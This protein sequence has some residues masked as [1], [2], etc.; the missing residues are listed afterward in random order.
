M[1]GN[2]CGAIIVLE[3]A[4]AIPQLFDDSPRGYASFAAAS[5]GAPF[6]TG[7]LIFALARWISRSAEGF[8]R[9]FQRPVVAEITSTCLVLAG[10]FPIVILLLNRVAGQWSAYFG[11]DPFNPLLWGV[12]SLA[13][14]AGALT[15]YLLHLWMIRRGM[16]LWGEPPLCEGHAAKKLIWY[17][18]AALLLLSSGLMLSATAAAIV[19]SQ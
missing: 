2:M 14:L 7:W 13:A 17:Q 8:L 1:A 6:L 5:F 4:L 12:R 10:V 16:I 15:A 11:L 18:Q 19:I 3:L 9:S